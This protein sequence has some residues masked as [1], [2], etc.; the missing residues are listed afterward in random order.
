MKVTIPALAL[1]ELE[2]IDSPQWSVSADEL[3]DWVNQIVER[4]LPHPE[5]ESG[6]VSLALS[7]RS[8]RHYQTLGCID[9]P[10]REGREARYKF[11]HYLQALLV[12]K[13]LWERV[14]ADTIGSL[15]AGKT[16]D[17]YKKLLLDG[18]EIQAVSA[19]RT[20]PEV[21]S[22]VPQSWLRIPLIKGVEVHLSP[23]HFS[24][25]EADMPHLLQAFEK[26]L[27]G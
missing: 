18:I 22:G 24:F 14:P 25:K 27:R 23:N 15:L 1:E 26:A 16:T 9:A 6:R 7:V 19:D 20:L 3:V 12:R 17:Q 10:V 13:L 4:F 5:P 11:R 2:M 8:L 21:L